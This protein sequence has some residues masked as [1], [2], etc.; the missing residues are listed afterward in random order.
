MSITGCQLAFSLN[1]SE[2]EFL[3]IGLPQQL[4]KLNLP[5][6]HLPNNATI[7]P[8]DTARHLGVIFD[9][10]LT[11]SDHIFSFSKSCF[12][13]ICDLRRIRNTIDH[14]PACTIATSLIH[15]KLD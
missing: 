14:T 8:V 3:I 5:I 15:S 6:I 10:N 2:T 1:P 13:H 4:A 9:K 7:S 11:F 12:Y